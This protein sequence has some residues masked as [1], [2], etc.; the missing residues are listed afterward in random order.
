MLT[1]I[2]MHKSEDYPDEEKRR[3]K[4]INT[5]EGYIRQSE[6]HNQM[7]KT[8]VISQLVICHVSL[9]TIIHHD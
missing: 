7:M 4:Q 6:K 8:I 3:N 9:L 1:G 5:D 2:M